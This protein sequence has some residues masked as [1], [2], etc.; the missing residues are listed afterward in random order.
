MEWNYI[1]TGL[2]FR[3]AIEKAKIGAMQ[4]SDVQQLNPVLVPLCTYVGLAY[5][6]CQEKNQDNLARCGEMP[7]GL[8]DNVSLCRP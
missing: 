6:Y 8:G 2:T 7:D 5:R 1:Y 4:G 3:E